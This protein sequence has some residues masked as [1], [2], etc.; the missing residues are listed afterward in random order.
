MIPNIPE[1][2][3]RLNSVAFGR[4]K[5]R[6]RNVSLD[7]YTHYKH[8]KGVCHVPGAP[9]SNDQSYDQIRPHGE[10]NFPMPGFQGRQ[11]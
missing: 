7:S 6:I 3:T 10:P 8:K 2:L 5:G 9:K 4:L 1:K 11:D